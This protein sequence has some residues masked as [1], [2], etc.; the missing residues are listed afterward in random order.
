MRDRYGR[1]PKNN[2]IQASLVFK[3]LAE[4]Y[5]ARTPRVKQ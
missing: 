2:Y 4:N 3:E 5:R 1:M